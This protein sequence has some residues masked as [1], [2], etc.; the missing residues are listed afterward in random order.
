MMDWAKTSPRRDE[1][2]LSFGM[3]AHYIRDLID[4]L[5][6][7]VYMDRLPIYFKVESLAL[8]NRK[9]SPSASEVVRKNIGKSLHT[10]PQQN[11]T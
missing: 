3:C 11:T 9:F 5:V 8:G 10:Q 7:A 4:V 2:H 1:K 6:L